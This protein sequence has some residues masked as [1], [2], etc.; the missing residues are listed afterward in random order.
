M[1]RW[2]ARLMIVLGLAGMAWA[3]VTVLSPEGE[4]FTAWKAH[5]AQ[6]HLRHELRP[7]DCRAPR[8]LGDP[9]GTLVIGRI[10]LRTVVVQ[11]TGHGQL[12][13]GPGHYPGTGLPG[14]GRTI[15]VAGHR[16]TYGAPFRYV[17]DLRRGDA[18]SFCGDTYIVERT[19]I[20]DDSDWR[21]I[22]AKRSRETLILSAC[23]PVYS[24]SHRILVIAERK[25]TS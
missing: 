18:I 4:P 8:G 12:S 25:E 23:H 20:V 24:A 22:L 11:G 13:M 1:I 15:A 6:A 16:T 10:G 14:Q 17:N 21:P 3:A 9:V 5:R 7:A 2:T 19:K